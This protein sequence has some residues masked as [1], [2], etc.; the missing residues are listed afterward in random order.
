VSARYRTG[1]LT[2]QLQG[3]ALTG[4]AELTESGCIGFS[5][6]DLPIQNTRILQRAMQYAATFGYTVWLRPLEPWLGAGVAASGALATRMGLSGVPVLAP[7]PQ[8]WNWCA[9][10]AR[11]ACP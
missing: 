4:R 3:E 1:A 11:A 9:K 6:A 7:A 8:V 10:H 2:R 5:Q